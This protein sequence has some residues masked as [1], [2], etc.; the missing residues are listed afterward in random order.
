MMRLESLSSTVLD[1]K[2]PSK[3]TETLIFLRVRN[4][5]GKKFLKSQSVQSA[6]LLWY[7]RKDV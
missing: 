2:N 7:S 6:D 5:K 1:A 3:T 4:G